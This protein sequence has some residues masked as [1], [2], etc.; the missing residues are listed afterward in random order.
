MCIIMDELNRKLNWLKSVQS[1]QRGR[2]RRRKRNLIGGRRRRKQKGGRR[3][4]K[5]IKRLSG[6]GILPITKWRA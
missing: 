1:K 6:K 4:E 5:S 2:G 3:R